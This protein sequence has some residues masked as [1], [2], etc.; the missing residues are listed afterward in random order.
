MK[1]RDA[2]DREK[3]SK[4]S[5]H[6][7]EIVH[8]IAELHARAHEEVTRSRA[9]QVTLAGQLPPSHEHDDEV[10]FVVFNASSYALHAI[11]KPVAASMD[12]LGSLGAR[13]LNQLVDSMASYVLHSPETFL[14]PE[15]MA[16]RAPGVSGLTDAERRALTEGGADL[17]GVRPDRLSAAARTRLEYAKLVAESLSVDEAARM[18]KVD[19]SR[20]RQRLGGDPRSLFGIK[21]GKAWRIPRFQFHEKRVIPGIDAVIAKLPRDLS[22]VAVY[23]WFT[24]PNSELEL[25][26]ETVSPLDWLEAGGDPARVAELAAEL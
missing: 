19:S 4:V 22:P 25:D 8:S 5:A 13:S 16:R 20:I 1:S 21:T 11:T 26:D 17:D 24:S 2:M 6:L 7:G 3:K 23:R 14:D 10:F 18:L 9:P 12:T 15:P